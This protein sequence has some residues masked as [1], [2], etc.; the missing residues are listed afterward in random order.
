MFYS[1]RTVK[2]GFIMYKI[3][4]RRSWSGFKFILVLFSISLIGL[5]VGYA[6]AKLAG[7]SQSPQELLH[8]SEPTF[9]SND[10]PEQS[11]AVLKP[12]ENAPKENDSPK[13]LFMY[14]IKLEDGKTK[15]YSFST[16]EKVFSHTLPIEPKSLRAEDQAMLQEGIYL[17][18]KSELLSFTEDFCS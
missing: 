15:V 1:N 10:I 14:L 7:R 5:G 13:E 2:R 6:G 18:T 4:K 12:V 9:P 16:G 11:K 17:K 3:K 8:T